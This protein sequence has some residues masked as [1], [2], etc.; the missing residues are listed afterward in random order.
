MNCSNFNCVTDPYE[1]W[2]VGKWPLHEL[3]GPLEDAVHGCWLKRNLQPTQ[4]L[5][6]APGMLPI[7]AHPE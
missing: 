1:R 5:M 6:N 7:L 4:R 2:G 3:C